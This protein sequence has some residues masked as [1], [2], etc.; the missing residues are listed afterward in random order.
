MEKPFPS[1]RILPVKNLTHIQ[2]DFLKNR[3]TKT[4]CIELTE[5]TAENVDK[6]KKE[7]DYCPL[8]GLIS[9]GSLAIAT[10]SAFHSLNQPYAHLTLN[11]DSSRKPY[12]R[13]IIANKSRCQIKEEDLVIRKNT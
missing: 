9:I 2:K 1:I 8:L 11:H 12:S 10:C 13:K 7:C 6:A 3:H 4:Y 5:P